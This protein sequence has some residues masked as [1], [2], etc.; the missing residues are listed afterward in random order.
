LKK[1]IA[2]KEQRLKVVNDKLGLNNGS[3]VTSSSKSVMFYFLK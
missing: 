1:R 2:E 3:L